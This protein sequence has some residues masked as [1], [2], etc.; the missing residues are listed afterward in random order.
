MFEPVSDGIV[1][2]NVVSNKNYRHTKLAL[3]KEFVWDSTA[4]SVFAEENIT[5]SVLEAKNFTSSILTT[6]RNLMDMAKN[7]TRNIKK[8]ISLVLPKL[9]DGKPKC[10]GQTMEQVLE[11]TREEM[12]RLLKG[13]VYVD[14]S[15]I[16]VGGGAN[17][18]G[19]H[20]KEEG[21]P[22]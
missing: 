12:W 16:T 9:K 1:T 17:L 19:S 14:T 15:L 6:G 18:S 5:V 3:K 13:K 2:N 22:Q 21:A 11:Q 4:P 7:S 20:D 8:L 10:S